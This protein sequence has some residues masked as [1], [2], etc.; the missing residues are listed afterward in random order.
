MTRP[1]GRSLAVFLLFAATSAPAQQKPQ[2]KPVVV[3]LLAI[4]DFH[5]NLEPP[6]APTVSSTRL[7][8]AASST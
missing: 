2:P 7:P 3:Q 6:P 4:N 8:L 1:V 5:G